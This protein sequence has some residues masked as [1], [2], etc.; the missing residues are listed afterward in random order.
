MIPATQARVL[1][2]K[3]FF[4][5]YDGGCELDNFRAVETKSEAPQE[6]LDWA[7]DETWKRPDLPVR[8]SNSVNSEDDVAVFAFRCIPSL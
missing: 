5:A 6:F 8:G 7:E 4:C 1:L 3:Q 2:S